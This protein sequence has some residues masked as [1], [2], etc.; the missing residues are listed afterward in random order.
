MRR[1]A[2]IAVL[3]AAGLFAAG[4]FGFGTAADSD[5]RLRDPAF[6]DKLA[7]LD[8]LNCDRPT[9]M[10]G[11]SRTLLGFHAERFEQATGTPAFNFGTPATGPITHLVYLNRLLDRGITPHLLLLEVLPPMLADGDGGPIEQTFLSGERLTG[12]E[13]ATVEGF[14]FRADAVR[15]KWRESVYAPWYSL[16]CQVVGRL[17]PSWL[18]WN[19]R[20]DWG[21]KTDP[22]GWATPPRTSVTDDERAEHVAKARA[23]YADTLAGLNPDGRPLGALKRIV[24]TCRERGIPVVLV[25]MPEAT[26]FR[27]MY[28]AGL[29]KR[30]EAELQPL[31][32][33]LIDARGWLDDTDFYDG[34][35]PFTGGAERFTDE[36]AKRLVAGGRP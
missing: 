26:T 4:Q 12:G 32:V 5:A 18:P 19:H 28:P 14:G 31:G 10:I 30:I 13:V 23:E 36:L 29:D 8:R 17:A 20:Y 9:L 15:P 1:R 11:S 6:A 35:H 25:L 24:T 2:A 34:H 27:G 22:H 33:P 16:R 21:R 3:V 7:K